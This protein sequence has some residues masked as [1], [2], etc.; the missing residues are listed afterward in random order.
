MGFGLLAFAS[1]LLLFPLRILFSITSSNLV[2]QSVCYLFTFMGLYQVQRRIRNKKIYLAI[3]CS[4]IM[5][6]LVFVLPGS[7]QR[8]LQ[9]II[10]PFLFLCMLYGVKDVCSERIQKRIQRFT[11]LYLLMFTLAFIAALFVELPMSEADSVTKLI[12]MVLWILRF[13][14]SI[15]LILLCTA[16][17]T[18]LMDMEVKGYREIQLS[19]TRK[20]SCI[21]LTAAVSAFLL[22]FLT[23]G[24]YIRSLNQNNDNKKS[25]LFES[26][27]VEDMKL[28]GIGNM[29]PLDID[30]NVYNFDTLKIRTDQ[31]EIIQNVYYIASDFSCNNEWM[32]RTQELNEMQYALIEQ[33]EDGYY[34]L[35]SKLLLT[36]QSFKVKP[37]QQVCLQV[38]LY[39]SEKQLIQKARFPIQ[40]KELKRYRGSKD[41][42]TIE[43]LTCGTTMM[44]RS[45]DISISLFHLSRYRE[46]D[47]IKVQIHYYQ[48]QQM[49]AQSNVMVYETISAL[50]Y[51]PGREVYRT[52]EANGEYGMNMDQDIVYD[53]AVLQMTFQGEDQSDRILEIPLEPDS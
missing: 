52:M 17:N 35:T 53:R 38:A 12:I 25:M 44:I 29:F 39:D 31:E 41:G 34:D 49:I 1:F 20:H 40:Q 7:I 28:V 9:D 43:H 36:S 3:F 4:I 5:S 22:L 10:E 46:Y 50:P 24:S 19:H 16:I 33:T 32:S 45:P 13:V 27:L 48:N 26:N 15:M 11:I 42:I 37:N 2:L 23:Q 8:Y 14:S 51:H 47:T 30:Q 6:I 21:L 18:E